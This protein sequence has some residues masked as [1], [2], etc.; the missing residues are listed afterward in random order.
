MFGDPDAAS[1]DLRIRHGVGREIHE[2]PRADREPQGDRPW[3]S[4]GSKMVMDA[5]TYLA[6]EL[7]SGRH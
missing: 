6:E 2:Q 7:E 4:I 3:P 5:R 1:L